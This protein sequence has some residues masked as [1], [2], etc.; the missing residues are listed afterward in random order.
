MTS[1]TL[2]PCTCRFEIKRDPRT[3][4]SRTWVHVDQACPHHGAPTPKKAQGGKL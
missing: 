3:M 1:E 4:L 2:T